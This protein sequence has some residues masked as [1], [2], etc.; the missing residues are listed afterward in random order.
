MIGLQAI[1]YRLQNGD[2]S[3]SRK[4]SLILMLQSSSTRD[5]GIWQSDLGH[6]TLLL[7]AGLP[8]RN[9]KLWSG[10]PTHRNIKE[11]DY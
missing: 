6:S 5:G 7:L 1:F 10:A 2:H 4:F 9:C 3:E 11:L 8:W